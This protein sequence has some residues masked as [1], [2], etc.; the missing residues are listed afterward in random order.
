M[1]QFMEYG[2]KGCTHRCNFAKH[3][4]MLYFARLWGFIITGSKVH[5]RPLHKTTDRYISMRTYCYHP[6]PS[7]AIPSSAGGLLIWLRL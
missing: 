3:T 4:Q 6:L 5:R 2:P 1:Y 7:P